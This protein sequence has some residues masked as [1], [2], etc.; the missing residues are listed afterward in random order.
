MTHVYRLL[1]H[2]LFS[3]YLTSLR[4][5]ISSLSIT[6]ERLK[7]FVLLGSS[8]IRPWCCCVDFTVLMDRGNTHLSLIITEDIV[9]CSIFFS[10][11]NVLNK[12]HL[13][14]INSN[15]MFGCCCRY[16]PLHCMSSYSWRA[17]V[18]VDH[19]PLTEVCLGCSMYMF[20]LFKEDGDDTSQGQLK[21]F[22]K[23]NT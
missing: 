8:L 10:V 23:E 22:A 4:H 2:V 20:L 6:N 17:E 19:F 14:I 13:K 16:G 7:W 21:N 5:V 12:N 11:S 3:S 1:A 9:L 18:N 15:V